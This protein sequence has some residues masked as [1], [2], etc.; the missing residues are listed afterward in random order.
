MRGLIRWGAHRTYKPAA[1][2]LIIW[3]FRKIFPPKLGGAAAHR[4]YREVT[5]NDR[6]PNRLNVVQFFG[7]HFLSGEGVCR[8]LFLKAL[9]FCLAAGG[10]FLGDTRGFLTAATRFLF[11][12]T[13]LFVQVALDVSNDG[14]QLIP[15]GPPAPIAPSIPGGAPGEAGMP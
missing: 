15:A 13:R 8:G 14:H 4:F 12:A 6:I 11:S 3:Q 5:L 9:A 2:P 7:G 10:F 1:V